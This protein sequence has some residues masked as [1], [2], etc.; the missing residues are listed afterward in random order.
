MSTLTR[1][2]SQETIANMIAIASGIILE[3][4]GN[5][6]SNQIEKQTITPQLVNSLVA[7]KLQKLYAPVKGVN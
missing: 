2:D 3:V 6:V 5:D 7:A 4:A 1:D